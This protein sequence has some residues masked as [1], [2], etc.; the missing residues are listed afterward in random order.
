MG[1]VAVGGA[2]V[3][4]VG[5]CLMLVA[6]IFHLSPRDQLAGLGLEG[7]LGIA[8]GKV[9]CDAEKWSRPSQRTC[10][11]EHD[12]VRRM[13]DACFSETSQEVSRH[14]PGEGLV[15][16]SEM[17]RSGLCVRC[18]LAIESSPE[19]LGMTGF[20][21]AHEKGS[22]MESVLALV[23]YAGPK[24]QGPELGERNFSSNVLGD[25]HHTSDGYPA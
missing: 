23:T 7:L 18:Y 2:A 22:G 19:G 17:G 6:G 12:N 1:G 11:L 13:H 4:G 25:G 20:T 3:G 5:G 14:S 8:C 9:V 15:E 24:A 21:N 10:G 16:Y